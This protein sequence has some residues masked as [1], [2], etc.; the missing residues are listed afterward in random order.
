MN[1]LFLWRELR[2]GGRQLAL[3]WLCV[4][5]GVLAVATVGGWRHAIEVGMARDA[6]LSAGGDVVVF[7]TQPFSAPLL[8]ELS[9]HPHVLTQELFTVAVDPRSGRTLFSKLKAVGEGYPLY[10][11]VKLV[12][13]KDLR[14][15][16][17]R[18]LVVESRVLQR[19]HLRV[20][21]SLKVGEQIWPIVDESL[22]EPDR[23]L[24]IFGISGRIFLDQ[25]RLASTGLVARQGSYVERR[26]LL[27]SGEPDRL[28]EQLRRSALAEQERVESWRHSPQSIRR[29]VKNFFLF[30]DLVAV[31]TVALGGLGMQG[32]LAAWLAG[33]RS[34]L[35]IV[36]TL[37]ARHSWTVRH[38]GALVAAVTAL[39]IATGLGLAAGLLSLSGDWLARLLPGQDRPFLGWLPALQAAGLGALTSFVF[40]LGPLRQLRE[41]RPMA[42][43]P[44]RSGLPTLL[45]TTFVLLTCLSGEWLRALQ[46]TGALAAVM[47]LV[48]LLARALLWGLARWRPASLVLRTALRGLLGP[49]S[50]TLTVTTLLSSTLAVL[51]TLLLS[52]QA[53]DKAWVRAMPPDAPNLIFFDIQP[54][55]AA[56]FL[57]L[58]Q[59]PVPLYPSFRLRFLKVDG[60]PI[61]REPSEENE[62]RRDYRGSVGEA[63]DADERL[64]GATRLF[65]PGVAEQ[66]SLLDTVAASNHLQVGSKLS[67]TLQGVPME[68]TVSSLRHVTRESFRPTFQ[69]LFPPALVEGAPRGIFA[70]LRVPEEQI[71]PLQ[72]RVAEAFP[73]I[74]SFD[75]S[76]TIRLVSVKLK[77]LLALT[78]VLLILGLLPGGVILVSAALAS[79]LERERESAYYKVL[80]ATRGFV[81]KTV[82]WE[83]ALLGML[84][85]ALSLSLAGLTSW[86]LC[87]WLWDVPFEPGL[88]IGLTLML[89]PILLLTSLGGILCMPVVRARPA[90]FL[91][92]GLLAVGCQSTPVAVPSA[93]P[94]AK[95]VVAFG[96]SLTE[97][98]GVD[99]E[100]AYP[101]QLERRLRKDGLDWK[102]VNAGISG[103]TSSAARTRL[104]WVIGQL[105][106]QVLILE[107]GAND[108]LRGIEPELTEKNL[109][110]MLDTLKRRNVRV[111]LAGMR[112]LKSSGKDYESKFAGVYPRLAQKHSVALFP[113]FLEGVAGKR[114]LNQA[115]QIHPTEKGY[116]LIVDRLAPQLETLLK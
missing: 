83:N 77:Q 95:V 43:R 15:A 7:S 11:Q 88:G 79:R 4:V 73:G 80:G 99:P 108:G 63:L 67:L 23:P 25:A 39:A 98:L 24:G 84:C 54:E 71:G 82:L 69:V 51:F 78:W 59:K 38:Y 32:T 14:S 42:F 28:V 85:S 46:F 53:L 50:S 37:G 36:R 94:V 5:S 6:R 27:R 48:W 90:R 101:A 3:F 97:G 109:D 1:S 76:E 33:R 89:T 64:V 9:K 91:A 106:P 57:K 87:R 75:V 111:L 21:D 65:Q 44:G 115:D 49:G 105:K 13:G 70:L 56:G 31:F 18:G 110:A 62:N 61:T 74:T 103:E 10:G 8:R 114:E 96:D 52:A 47:G 19:L 45:L 66:A 68:V 113:F 81:L 104:D 29:F 40:T 16:L 86:G 112:V 92:L 116:S 72:S 93:T 100:K 107:T 41:T 60:Q 2:A 22:S 35:A 26:A 58:L 55:Q 12:S 102:V 20:G 30:L 17:K 34:V